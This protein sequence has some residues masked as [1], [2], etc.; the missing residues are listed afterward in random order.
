MILRISSASSS[1]FQVHHKVSWEDQNWKLILILKKM[2]K[3]KLYP[4]IHRTFAHGR[5]LC[6]GSFDKIMKQKQKRGMPIAEATSSIY[7]ALGWK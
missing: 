4:K 1:A 6:W 2:V 3:M 7:D 5:G